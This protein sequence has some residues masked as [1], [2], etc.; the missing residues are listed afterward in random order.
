MSRSESA[1]FF[2]ESDPGSASMLGVQQGGV[3]LLETRAVQPNSNGSG[4]TEAS[5]SPLAAS[6]PDEPLDGSSGYFDRHKV[7]VACVAL[8]CLIC[9]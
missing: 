9:D 2:S 6:S 4:V 8:S 3:A 1:T 5:S 7:Y